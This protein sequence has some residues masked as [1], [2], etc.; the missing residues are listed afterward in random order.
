MYPMTL[1]AWGYIVKYA[2]MR[3]GRQPMSER[4]Q[5]TVHQTLINALTILA[6]QGDD[7]AAEALQEIQETDYEIIENEPDEHVEM[8]LKYADGTYL[9]TEQGASFFPSEPE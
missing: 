1:L 7:R 3:F 6:K 8:I 2:F 4:I 5:R 9:V